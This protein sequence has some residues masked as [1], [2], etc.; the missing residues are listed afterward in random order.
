M[1]FQ[2]GDRTI[3]FDATKVYFF[4]HSQGGLTGPGF[5]AFEPTLSGAVFSGTGGLL[6]LGLLYKTKP[7]DVSMLLAT[8]LRDDP[9]DEDNP[10]LAMVQM[11]VERADGANYAPMFVR[12]PLGTPRN[13]FQTEGFTDT[14]TPNPSIEAFAVAVG[15]DLVQLADTKDITGLTALRGRSVQAAPISGNVGGATAALGQYK[16][17]SGSDGHF[18]VFDIAIAERQAA[19][20]LG[21]LAQTG[22]ATVVP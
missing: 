18:V 5:V 1:S 20:F 10:S 4:G 8:F 9:V 12:R 6:Y 7:L 2:D 3:R 13:I 16:Q 11:W 17:R 21:T 14:Y 19:S 22:T 15:G